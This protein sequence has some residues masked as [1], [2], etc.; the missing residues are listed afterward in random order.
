MITRDFAEHFSSDWVAA[1]NAHDLDAVL[2]HY[3]DGFSM[4]SPYIA[5]IAGVASGTLVGKEAVRAYWSAALERMPTL[6]FELVQT[7]I[8]V[9]S[10]TLYYRGVRGMA[11]EVF[12]FDSDG[13]VSRAMAHYE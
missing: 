6:R 2:S 9:D 1:W 7:L 3:A 11:A 13:K 12:L 10:L 4:S 5:Q 8:G